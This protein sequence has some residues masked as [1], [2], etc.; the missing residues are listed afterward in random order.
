MKRWR[1]ESLS[2]S[3]RKSSAGDGEPCRSSTGGPVP[4]MRRW[5]ISS[6]PPDAHAPGLSAVGDL[7]LLD[8][9]V[10][11]A[12]QVLPEHVRALPYGIGE[13]P[14]LALRKESEHNGTWSGYA[15]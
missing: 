9:E 10:G 7:E 14:T 2:T 1:R 5:I 8:G 6:S 11:L 12:G 3:G 15:L 4:V 13:C